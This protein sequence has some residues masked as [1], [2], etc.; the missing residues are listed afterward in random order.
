[1]RVR[2]RRRDD[3]PLEQKPSEAKR[4]KHRAA[5][6]A[7]VAAE[8]DAR[9]LGPL[10]EGQVDDTS[11]DYLCSLLA[12]FGVACIPC[13]NDGEPYCASLKVVDLVAM[14]QDGAVTPIELENC[15]ETCADSCENKECAEASKFEICNQ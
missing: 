13:A 11:P 2:K 5:G 15:H 12:G 14:E 7:Q 9:D 4:S 6:G 8:I 1:M 10:L 3:V